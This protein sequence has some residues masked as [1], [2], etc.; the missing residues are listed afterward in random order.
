[1]PGLKDFGRGSEIYAEGTLLRGEGG[2]LFRAQSVA[3]IRPPSRDEQFR[4]ALRMELLEKT[5]SP[6][7]G[8]LAQA[9]LLGARD[10]LDTQLSRDFRDAGCSHILALSGM[11]LAVFSALIALLLKKPLGVRLASLTGALFVIFYVYLAGAQPSLVRSAI[12]YLLGCLAV[13]C[14]F[15]TTTLTLLALSFLAQL[16]CFRGS[17]SSPSFILSYLALGG[18]LW[19]GESLNEI[20]RGRLPPPLASGLSASLGAFIA[21]AAVSLALFGMLRPVGILAGMVIAPLASLFMILALGGLAAGFF[22]PPLFALFD[23]GLSL[24]YRLLE[25][26]IS[27]AAS[28]PGIET[29]NLPAALLLSLFAAGFISFLEARLLRKRKELAPFD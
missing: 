16:L 9:L 13:W 22:A 26:S 14:S 12:M 5:S 27:L 7:W 11:H 15:K 18:I 19:T 2:P 20:F 4:T 10:N 8:G 24:L 28:F 1:M 6:V 21:T 17:A 3:V 25:G 23:K 29:G